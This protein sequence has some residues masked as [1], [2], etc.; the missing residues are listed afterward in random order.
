M[1]FS[2]EN[3]SYSYLQIIVHYV[4]RNYLHLLPPIKIEQL[5]LLGRVLAL[6]TRRVTAPLS[7]ETI[8]RDTMDGGFPSQR[9][10]PSGSDVDMVLGDGSHELRPESRLLAL[11]FNN[12]AAIRKDARFSKLQAR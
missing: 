10:P 4:S 6:E 2:P 7:T 11:M 1:D 3:P 5:Y 12:L 8:D 9:C